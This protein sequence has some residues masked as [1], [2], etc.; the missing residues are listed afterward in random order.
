MLLSGPDFAKGDQQAGST[1]FQNTSLLQNAFSKDII[2]LKHH[3][4]NTFFSALIIRDCQIRGNACP[5][6]GS[7]F[8]LVINGL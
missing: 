4:V 8:I 1:T 5:F 3:L 7:K 6:S 2:Y